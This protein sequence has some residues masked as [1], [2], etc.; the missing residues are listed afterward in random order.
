MRRPN[1]HNPKRMLGNAPN[2]HSRAASMAKLK[3]R[4]AGQNGGSASVIHGSVD[5]SC[6][7]SSPQR[8]SRVRP[9]AKLRRSPTTRCALPDNRLAQLNEITATSGDDPE[10]DMLTLPLHAE[11]ARPPARRRAGPATTGP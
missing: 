1:L 5:H 4:T 9:L 6:L 8:R 11:T 10:L 7:P 2:A 3:G